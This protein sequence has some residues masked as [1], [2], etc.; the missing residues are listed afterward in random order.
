MSRIITNAAFY[1]EPPCHLI[2]RKDGSVFTSPV[3]PYDPPVALDDLSNDPDFIFSFQPFQFRRNL[4]RYPQFAF[5]PKDVQFIG[6]LLG[7]LS[8][9]KVVQGKDGRYGMDPE[10]LASW[11]WLEDTLSVA[12]SCLSEGMLLPMQVQFYDYPQQLG[13]RRSFKR[14]G[15]AVK[16]MITARE[17]FLVMIGL[18]SMF[19]SFRAERHFHYT[20][21]PTSQPYTSVQTLLKKGSNLSDSIIQDLIDMHS[22]LGTRIGLV[23]ETGCSWF[24]QYRFALAYAGV[25]FWLFWGKAHPTLVARLSSRIPESSFLFKYLPNHEM[26]RRCVL[27]LA[28]NDSLSISSQQLLM[29]DARRHKKYSAEVFQDALPP[30]PQPIPNPQHSAETPHDFLKRRAE[31]EKVRRDGASHIE[32]QRWEGRASYAATLK[33]GVSKKSKVYYWQSVAGVRRRTRIERAHIDEIWDET[34]LMKKR[35]PN[36]RKYNAVFD[37]WDVC[38]D[39]DPSPVDEDPIEDEFFNDEGYEDDAPIP[40]PNPPTAPAR[41]PPKQLPLAHNEQGLLFCHARGVEDEEVIT[42]ELDDLMYNRY[43]FLIDS[44]AFDLRGNVLTLPS[45]TLLLEQVPRILMEKNATSTSRSKDGIRYLITLIDNNLEI[46]DVYW[47]IKN[48]DLLQANPRHFIFRHTELRSLQ[49]G[50][51]LQGYTVTPTSSS[52]HRSWVLFVESSIAVVQCIREG[53]GPSLEDV[54]CKACRLGY[55]THIFAVTRKEALPPLSLPPSLFSRRER[56]AGFIPTH[57]DFYA[58]QSIVEI[59]VMQPRVRAAVLR[60]GILGRI[61]S[62]YISLDEVADG[63]SPDVLRYG[64]RWKVEGSD[65]ILVEDFISEEEIALL[66]GFWFVD[67]SVSSGRRGQF[68]I[69]SFFPTPDIWEKSGIHTA[70]WSNS[71]EEKFRS[72]MGK[73]D[74]VRNQDSPFP[75]PVPVKNNTEWK[76]NLRLHAKHTKK[77]LSYVEAASHSFIMSLS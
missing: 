31:Q 62:P 65:Q 59:L 73:L 48:K 11:T 42:P 13:Y 75:V 15:R 28:E 25:P 69:F 68:K 53:W 18:F 56:E 24:E 45:D 30:D 57:F 1:R 58:Y 26:L 44:V 35:N 4:D 14:H 63:P 36:Q 7:R 2:V 50:D 5:I 27:L 39:F 3:A 77:F 29:M 6:P 9:F 40:L 33:K 20:C 8:C 61:C 54:V 71:A 76:S 17:T 51:P 49:S 55:R 37:E 21:F 16:V 72:I 43:G 10:L 70:L 47:D 74:P 38:T 22:L 19:Y 66:C 64:L 41:L 52:Y 32:L 23:V 67:N 46:P 60:G 12:I 34:A